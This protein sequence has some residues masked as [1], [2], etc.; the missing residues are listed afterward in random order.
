MIDAKQIQSVTEI[1]EFEPTLRDRFAMA[2]LTG[3]V[4]YQE[5]DQIE[6]HAENI[7][8]LAYLIASAM[9]KARQK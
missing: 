2:A 9:M 7:V 6:K 5:L 1:P 3:L 8:A 4:A